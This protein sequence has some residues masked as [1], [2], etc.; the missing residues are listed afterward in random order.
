MILVTGGTGFV[1]SH[2]VRRLCKDDVPVRAIAR[3]PDKAQALKDLGVDVVPGDINDMVSLERAAS[4]CERVV[5]VVSSRNVG[6]DLSARARGW[7]RN[8]LE[9]EGLRVPFLLSEPSAPGRSK[10]AYHKSK[11][12]S[13]AQRGLRAYTISASLIYGPGD[14]FTI[15]LSDMIRLSPVCGHRFEIKV[16]PLVDDVVTASS[17]P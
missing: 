1:G 15:R 2:L 7:R 6:H 14:Q 13:K 11:W 8:L 16:Q 3:N 9:E 12:V 17:R 4:G 10:G 5:L